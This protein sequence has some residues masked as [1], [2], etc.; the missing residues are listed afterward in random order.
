MS[1]DPSLERAASAALAKKASDVVVL[2]LR[3][4][5]TFTDFFLIASGQGQKQLVAIA[6]AILEALRER[7]RRPGHVE[8]YP[9]QDWILLDFDDFIVHVMTPRSR[10]FYALERLWGEAVRLEVAG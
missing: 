6:D 10:G 7:R 2:D 1:L 9:R 4:Q 8:G 5:A 3:G